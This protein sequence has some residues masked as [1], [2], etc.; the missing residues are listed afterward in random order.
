MQ[1]SLYTCS[2]E[3][4]AQCG[5]NW[6]LGE[7]PNPTLPLCVVVRIVTCQSIHADSDVTNLCDLNHQESNFMSLNVCLQ[8]Y[9]GTYQG[10][11]ATMMKQG[12][13][14]AIRFFVMDS[15]KV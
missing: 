4:V 1:L 8:V 9:R 3:S 13:N 7:A 5:H 6:S 11:T 12:S 2:W 14:Q 15:L 10:L